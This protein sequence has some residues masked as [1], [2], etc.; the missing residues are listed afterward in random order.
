VDRDGDGLCQAEEFEFA[1]GYDNFAGAYWGHRLYDLTFRVLATVKGRR[2]LVT[3]KPEGFL[4]SGAPKYPSLKDATTAPVDLTGN[5]IE[6]AVDRFGNVVCNSDPEMKCFAPDGR[7]LWTYP[8]RWVGV[9][10]SHKAPLPETGV[11]QG[12]LYFLGMAP[13]DERGDVFVMN[14]NHGRFFAL[15]SDGLYL[16]EM[17]KDVRMGGSV[18]AHLIG[19]ECFGGF[20]GRSAK[21]GQYYLQSGHTDYRIFR[22][23]GLG[24]ARR[25]GGSLA[26]TA[27][28]AIAAANNQM[29]AVAETAERK[30]AAAPFVAKAPTL[31]G[32][33]RDW[34][35]NFDIRWSKG[36]KFPVTVR[37]AWDASTL[38]IHYHVRDASPWVNNGKDWTTL[39][40]TGDSV[41]VQLGTDPK[42]D[43]ARRGPVPG[44]LRLLIAPFQGKDVAVLYRHRVPG[45][46]DPVT[47]TSPWRSEKVDVVARL[48][49][50]KIAVAK[51]QDDYRVEVA[52]PLADLGL[53]PPGAFRADFGVIYGDPGGAISMLR[54]YWSNQATGLMNDVP[55][56]IMLHPNL[57]GT[58]TLKGAGK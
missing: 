8:N 9:H 49:G 54:A 13:L 3:L 21:D 35:R 17:F 10:G 20:F 44:D 38:Y 15:T 57:W 51:G 33:D 56:E 19:G 27:E 47:F 31:D 40:K 43:R 58:L 5:E 32:D 46:K 45:A 53:E 42:A 34:S 4:P 48:D 23:D 25:S 39:F 55:G 16:D 41:D 1:T 28:Q 24:E 30:E 18:D 14:G 29:R 50:A 52:I 36:G 7:T 6:T 22:I 37:A 11:M 12:A 26:V 2:V